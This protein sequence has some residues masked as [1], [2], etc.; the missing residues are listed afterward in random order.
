MQIVTLL[1]FYPLRDK[2]LYITFLGWT[3][4]SNAFLL[5]PGCMSEKPAGNKIKESG[6]TTKVKREV[7]V[8]T[9]LLG[10]DKN[11]VIGDKVFSYF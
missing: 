1:L 6:V 8:G 10:N 2:K 9:L 4:S 5:C 7:G 11:S 3:D